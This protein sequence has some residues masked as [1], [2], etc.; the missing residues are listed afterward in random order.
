[1]A[2]ART[3]NAERDVRT[4]LDA[5]KIL[6]LDARA[7]ELAGGVR[8]LLLQRREDI[9]V[10]DSLVAG[11]CLRQVGMLLTRN[12]KHF[13]RVDGLRLATLANEAR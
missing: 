12:R 4:L 13:E 7:A 1:L 11:I 6:P 9:G 2:G 8:R 10:A 3:T 5:L